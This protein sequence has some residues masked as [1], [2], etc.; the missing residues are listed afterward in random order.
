MGEVFLTSF[1]KIQI[2]HIAEQKFQNVVTH[3][4]FQDQRIYG[5]HGHSNVASASLLQ[6][7]FIVYVY[8]MHHDSH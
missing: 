5:V 8:A 1:G 2:M 4:D 7:I 6:Q 3:L